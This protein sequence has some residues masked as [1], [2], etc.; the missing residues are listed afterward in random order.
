[1][2]G[3]LLTVTTYWVVTEGEATGLEIFELER[4]FE[5]DQEMLVARRFEQ[6]GY[7]LEIPQLHQDVSAF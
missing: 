6:A 7:S 4:P 3:P 5:G 2:Q 1:M